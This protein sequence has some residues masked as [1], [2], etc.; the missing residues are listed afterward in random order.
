[1]DYAA[2][3][4]ALERIARLAGAA[5][6]EVYAGDFAADTK[7]D[8][9][10][11]TEAD[12]R[13]EALILPELARLTPDIP[14]IAEESVAAGHVPAIGGRFWL[15]DPLDGTKEFLKRNGEFTVNIGL[16]DGGLPRAGVVFAPALAVLWSGADGAG[17]T[18][19]D[20]AGRR[21]AAC[22]RPPDSG[23]VVL[24]SRSHGS[25]GDMAAFLAGLSDPVVENSGSSLKF[26][27]VAEGSADFYPRFGP[28]CEWD[29]AAAHAVLH[30]AGGEVVNLDGS[31]FA[32]G[33]APTF[34]N[35]GFL[36]R[37]V[38]GIG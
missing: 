24:G 8:G 21:P 36:A 37:A 13:A 18:R 5:I 11:V 23:A 22:R 1:M 34:L 20:A 35:P 38:R 29:T 15:V 27:R 4:P 7:G 28:T 30:A 17:T 2:L 10:P 14:V 26:C 19:V 31:P 9:S 12:Q 3:L 32:Y 6:L 25:A 16:V 33:K